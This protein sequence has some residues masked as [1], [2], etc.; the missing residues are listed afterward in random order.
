MS[1]QRVI[2]FSGGRSSAMLAVKYY[3]PGDIV[4]F[5]NTGKEV[6]ETLQFIK[7]CQDYF[8]L[9]IVWLEYDRANKFRIV[10]FETASRNGEPY[11][12]LISHR[13][14]LPN[15]MTRYCT[16][17]LKMKVEKYYLN[18]IGVKNY[19][20]L[21]GI[22]ADEPRRLIKMELANIKG[23]NPFEYLTPLATERITKAN[24]LEFWKSQ[25]FDLAINGE[26]GNC[27]LCFLKG[28]N[29]LIK[30]IRQNPEKADWWIQQEAEK[31]TFLNGISYTDL[32]KVALNQMQIDFEQ[33]EIECFCNAD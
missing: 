24:V 23:D 17:D 4:T 8:N 11:A 10:T 31:G 14:T 15:I 16:S 9:P 6:E 13:K 25:P 2:S 7:Q 12:E 21:V 33:G 30:L 22:R 1:M 27:D 3:Q 20:K 32:K 19:E 28:R 29:K 18:S 26:Y 5:Q